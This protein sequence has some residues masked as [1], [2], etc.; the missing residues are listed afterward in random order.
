MSDKK[1][2]KKS[3]DKGEKK[4]RKPRDPSKPKK[5]KAPW[6]AKQMERVVK[7]ESAA[8]KLHKLVL[9][10]RAPN[11]SDQFT[12]LILSNL[13]GMK[14]QLNTLP[15]DWKPARGSTPGTDK[16]TGIGS[17]IYVKADLDDDAKKLYTT[18]F[19]VSLFENAQIIDDDGR[20]WVVRCRDS[21][22]RVVKKK[23][24]ALVALVAQ[25]AS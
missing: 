5:Q 6:K 21:M 8:T 15:D 14:A 20:N 9:A 24:V 2:E 17:V 3:D 10:A 7:L 4:K 23:H 22:T 11:V 16:K 19:P 1:N 25:Q 12:N 18:H 13:A